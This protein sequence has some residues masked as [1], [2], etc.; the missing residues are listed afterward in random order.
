MLEVDDQLLRWSA[1]VSLTSTHLLQIVIILEA[2]LARLTPVFPP[3]INIVHVLADGREGGV[4]TY[5]TSSSV[6][7]PNHS[8]SGS[9][10]DL[11][12]QPSHA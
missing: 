6:Q 2:S 1:K 8:V 5:I 3:V 11:K 9:S 7:R 4:S 12:L 10:T